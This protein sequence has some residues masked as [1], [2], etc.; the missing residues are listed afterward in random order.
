MTSYISKS[1]AYPVRGGIVGIQEA[2]VEA[3]GGVVGGAGN[4]P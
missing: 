1:D 3:R 4:C 2:R